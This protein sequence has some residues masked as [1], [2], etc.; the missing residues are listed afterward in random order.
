[1][2]IVEDR[3]LAGHEAARRAMVESQLRTSG[4][5]ADWLLRRMSEVAREQFV[6]AAASSYA[7]IDRAIAIDGTHH[8]AA[9]VVQGMMLQ[10]A[11]PTKDDKVL[12]VDC[13]SGYL[14]ELVRPL[15]GSLEVL[16]PSEAV[17][18]ARKAGDFTLLL[19]DGAIEQLPDSLVGRLAEG[20]RVVTGLVQNGISR[21]AIGR[22]AAGEVAL[23]PLAELGIPSLPEFAAPKG[24]RF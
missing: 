14:A 20:A 10:E 11:Q 1:M 18:K 9:P 16:S 5:N 3:P 8:L 19:I 2:T 21:L 12:L 7:Y 22:K 23:F 4:V 15:V 24:W 13:G 6:P 17:A